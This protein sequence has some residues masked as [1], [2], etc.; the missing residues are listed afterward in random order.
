M[1]KLERCHG[2]VWVW[3][4]QSWQENNDTAGLTKRLVKPLDKLNK[5]KIKKIIMYSQGGVR[6]GIDNGGFGE[7][8]KGTASLNSGPSGDSRN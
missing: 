8:L 6:D 5:N 2:R 1:T 7:W 4:K 3:Q